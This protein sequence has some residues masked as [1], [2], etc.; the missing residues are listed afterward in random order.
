MQEKMSRPSEQMYLHIALVIFVCVLVMSTKAECSSLNG[1]H[2]DRDNRGD[3]V[4]KSGGLSGLLLKHLRFRELEDPNVPR[5]S[6][7]I[8]EEPG[9]E[10]SKRS[11]DRAI[12]A[13]AD[14]L[15]SMRQK[16]HGSGFRMQTLRF[17]RRR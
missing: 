16:Q 17:G 13:L 2:M 7:T 9:K 4:P 14:V 11:D 1:E 15:A 5:E 8:D 10:Y 3:K 6:N 12:S